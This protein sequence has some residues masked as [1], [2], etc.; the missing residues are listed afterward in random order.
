M[1]IGNVL[2]LHVGN[3]PIGKKVRGT[4]NFVISEHL[5]FHCKICT[6]VYTR[7]SIPSG[8]SKFTV[9][10]KFPS[11]QIVFVNLVVSRASFVAVEVSADYLNPRDLFLAQSLFCAQQEVS[12]RT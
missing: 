6:I 7:I 8:K 10:S 9:G 4:F 11:L 12:I 5:L 1:I 2:I 3:G